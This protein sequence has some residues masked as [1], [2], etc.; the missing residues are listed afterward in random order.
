MNE[1]DCRGVVTATLCAGCVYV[2]LLRAHITGN[3]DLGQVMALH[4]CTTPCTA[5]SCRSTYN[6]YMWVIFF[7]AA[8]QVQLQTALRQRRK[9]SPQEYYD[10]M[11]LIERRFQAAGYVPTCSSDGLLSGTFYLSTVDSEHRGCY[12]RR[13]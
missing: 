9:V 10:A 3:V 7:P 2:R 1:L 8:V 6:S 5:T 11:H 12:T 4:N 13:A